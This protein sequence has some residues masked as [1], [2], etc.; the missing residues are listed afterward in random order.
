[1]PDCTDKSDEKD[2]LCSK[3]KQSSVVTKHNKRWYT[4]L[5]QSEESGKNLLLL[6]KNGQE[7]SIFS[8]IKKNEFMF[9]FLFSSQ[10]HRITT[11]VKADSNARLGK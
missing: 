6:R 9:Y 11:A 8:T 3:Y 2:S 5:F 10:E 4:R 1:V 7:R